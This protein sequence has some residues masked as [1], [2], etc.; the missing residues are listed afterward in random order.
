MPKHI[1]VAID[2]R[3]LRIA[4]TGAKTYLEELC[5]V[6]KVKD[7]AFSFVLLDTFLPVYT[8]KIKWLKLIEQCR[9][10]AWKQL[11]L[12]FLAFCKGCDIIFCTDF[13]VPYYAWG[14]KT[15][16]VFHD[17]FLWEY[18]AHYN[19]YWLKLFYKLGVGAAKK[20]TF[21][22]TSSHY[23][24]ERIAFF[25]GIDAAKIIPIYEAPKQLKYAEN[26]STEIM[27][28]DQA[29]IFGTP[30]LLHV[31]TFEKRKN[32][33]ILIRAFHRLHKNGFENLKLVLLGQASPKKDMDDSAN[34]HAL[35]Q[36]FG[37]TESV[38]IPG[39]VSDTLLAKFYQHATIYVFPS[40]NEGFG[41]PVLEAFNYHLPVIIANN[42]CLPEIAG[43]AAWSFDP[44][45]ESILYEK[46]QILLENEAARSALS[47][48]G[49]ERL[50]FFSW[51]KAAG[52]LK[53]IFQK[54][55]A[56]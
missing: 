51:E 56:G 53:I 20:S 26:H 17:A 37:L 15:I 38:F 4:R 46:L 1:K 44:D 27:P 33:P 49:V 12:P 24:K 42:T 13:F 16:P 36:E 8:G 11:I 41:I 23:S 31:G 47:K 10:M 39:Y 29:A 3:D 14:I 9:F 18:P 34:I 52:E 50:T 5:K 30:Y 2:I 48:K 43:N 28:P 54:A 25:S 45:D 21:V 22:I 19:R 35:I 7:P 6:F 40:R 32:L 55:V